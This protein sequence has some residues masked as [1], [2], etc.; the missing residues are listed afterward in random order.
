V[1]DIK[2]HRLRVY[3]A[4]VRALD[5]SV[6]RIMA[7]LEE[8]G[9]AENTIVIFSSDNGGAGYIGLPEVNAP[10]RGWKL[11]MFEGGI[12]VPM[13]VK[14]PSRIAPGTQVDTPVAH[15]DMM[16]TLAAAAQAGPP[17]DVAIDGVNLLPLATGEGAQVLSRQTLYWQSAYYRVVRHGD[18]KLQVS[19]RPKKN[20]LY[21]LAEDPTEQNNLA[22]T[23]ADKREELMALL[24]A[25]QASAREPLYPHTV[26]VPVAID[27]TLVEHFE[28]GDEYIYWPN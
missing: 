18:W 28:A 27:K 19:E 13:F 1:G 25:H 20:W 12:R 24:D 22:E 26:E 8:E 23:R 11:T 9:L 21:N 4:M 5:R 15:I 16:P 10:Y 6:G 2:P 3:A 17:Q 14:W 7:T